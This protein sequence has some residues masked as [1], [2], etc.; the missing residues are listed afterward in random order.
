MSSSSD[1]KLSLLPV[2]GVRLATVAAGIKKSGHED[3]L[4]MEIADSAQVAAVFTANRF[5]AAPVE[6]CRQYLQQAKPR[7]LLINSGNAN[8]G[9]GESGLEAAR[10]CC[11]SVASATAVSIENVLPFSTG[12]I[13]EPLP[14]EKIVTVIPRFNRL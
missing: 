2:D 7:Y 10:I 14:A 3:L 8:C 11:E 9:L 4:L 6:L 13:A 12:V 5:A 1:S